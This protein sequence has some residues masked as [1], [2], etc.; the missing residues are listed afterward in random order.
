M[1]KM[2]HSLQ[3]SWYSPPHPHLCNCAVLTA[4]CHPARAYHSKKN[5]S[6]E[7]RSSA[8]AAT[9]CASIPQPYRTQ[10][11]EQR[12]RAHH[13]LPHKPS[14]SPLLAG[15]LSNLPL[16]SSRGE[17]HHN[18]PS[19][20]LRQSRCPFRQLRR[21]GHPWRSTSQST[22]R[23]IRRSETRLSSPVPRRALRNRDAAERHWTRGRQD[24]TRLHST[25][26]STRKEGPHPPHST[27]PCLD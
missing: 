3:R 19:T 4:R 23:R 14:V 1:A 15:C 2:A 22:S 26:S 5:L 20:P 10:G 9:P 18:Q 17:R 11:K 12:I 16:R 27:C 13:H 24:P 6:D 8:R 21:W 7:H 25:L